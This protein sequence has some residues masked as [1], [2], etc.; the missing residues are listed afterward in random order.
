[1]RTLSRSLASGLILA[2]ALLCGSSI[3]AAETVVVGVTGPPNALGWPFEVAIE[4]GFFAAE[5]ITIDRIAAPSSA[6]VILQA[7]ASA[8]DMTVQGAF[9]DVI[10]AIEKG[11]PL[12]VVRITL[13]TPPYELNAKSSI[14]SL[15]DLKGK[16]I[17]IGGAKDITRIFVER[18][19][20]AKGL[21][22]G[23]YDFV[24]AGATSARFSALQAGAVD[25]AILTVPFN[26]YG[27]S[28]G[29]TNLG[30]TFDTLP[31]MPFA[32]MA[33][34]RAWASANPK[35]VERFLGAIVKGVAWFED[36]AHRGEAV[37][38]MMSH[39]KTKQ[40]DIERSYDFLRDK[41]LFEPSGKVSRRKIGT[42]VEALQELGDVPVGFSAD[43]LFLPGVTQLVD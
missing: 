12:A 27:E 41:H 5:G 32:G 10:R 6:A 42:V 7:T 33:V 35:V 34:N 31:D 29:F 8:L 11:A 38:L 9:V 20:A 24:F 23:D 30:F 17:I 4:K 39:S 16:T 18:M 28:A 1:M 19:L 3:E 36:A 13:Q 26:F 25:A 21:K 43:R 37:S 2:S 15:K 40:E 22:A 14:K